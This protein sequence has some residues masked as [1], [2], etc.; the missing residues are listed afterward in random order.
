[1]LLRTSV[2]FETDFEVFDG[3]G[4]RDGIDEDFT[5]ERVTFMYF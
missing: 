1:M 2:P 5:F 4:A 3:L